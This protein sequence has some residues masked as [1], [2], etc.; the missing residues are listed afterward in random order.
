MTPSRVR[1]REP[2]SLLIVRSVVRGD[3]RIEF[4]MAAAVSLVD[5]SYAG[6]GLAGVRR[7]LGTLWRAFVTALAATAFSPLTIGL[8]TAAG[9]G[10]SASAR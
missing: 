2:V 8:W 7:A 9:S 3:F 10:S 6:L 1:S 5:L 4:A